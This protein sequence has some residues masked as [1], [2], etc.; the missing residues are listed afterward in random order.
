LVVEKQRPGQGKSILS[1]SNNSIF[2]SCKE[3]DTQLKKIKSELSPALVGNM[4][5]S[6]VIVPMFSWKVKAR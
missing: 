4:I 3:M 5:E 1:Y 6:I 2:R